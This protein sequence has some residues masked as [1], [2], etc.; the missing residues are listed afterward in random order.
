MPERDREMKEGDRE[1]KSDTIKKG[2]RENPSVK[3][4]SELSELII[5]NNIEV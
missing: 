2:M 4:K 3:S 5:K 1:N